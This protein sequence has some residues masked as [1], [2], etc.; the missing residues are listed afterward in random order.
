MLISSILVAYIP[1]LDT[2]LNAIKNFSGKMLFIYVKVLIFT[3]I[4]SYFLLSYFELDK[5]IS[6]CLAQSFS[7]Y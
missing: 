7:F 3:I 4:I 1:T 2:Y 6:F 5:I